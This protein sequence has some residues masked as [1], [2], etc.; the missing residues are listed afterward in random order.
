MNNHSVDDLSD[1]ELK[2]ARA[3][4]ANFLSSVDPDFADVWRAAKPFTMLSRER[5]YDYYSAVTHAVRCDVVG[6]V[7]EV[8]AW[9]GGGCV[10]AALAIANASRYAADTGLDSQRIV[11]GFDTFEGHPPPNRGETDVWGRD[12]SEVY[13][14]MAGRP[15]AKIDYDTCRRVVDDAV[16]PRCRVDLIKGLCQETIPVHAPSQISVLRLDVDWYEPTL[17][18]LQLLYPRLTVGGVCIIDDFG[19]HSGARKAFEEYFRTVGLKSK[20]FHTDYSC[21]S[22]QKI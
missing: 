3:H 1:Y 13:S 12:Q 11:F 22:F 10:A 15:W 7:V 4:S 8:G 17:L 2:I 6:H 21:I 18:S 9:S 19:H 16:G 20:I 5:L 14:E